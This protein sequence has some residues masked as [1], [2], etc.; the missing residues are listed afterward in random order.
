MV[1]PSPSPSP[2]PHRRPAPSH[3]QRLDAAVDAFVRHGSRRAA[4][5]PL[6]QLT[7][8]VGFAAGGLVVVSLT[9][10]LGS[11]VDIGSWWAEPIVLQKLVVWTMMWQLLG[12]GRG[13]ASHGIGALPPVAGLSYWLTPGTV[14]LAPWPGRVPLTAGT[15][16]TLADVVLYAV[17][18]ALGAG[19]LGF[20]GEAGGRLPAAGTVALL[21]A[22][23]LL[24]L[25]D[26]TPVLAARPELVVPLLVAFLLP[27]GDVLMGVKLVLASLCWVGAVVAAHRHLPAAIATSLA[28]APWLRGERLRTALW[29]RDD[30]DIVPGDAVRWTANLLI[31]VGL[32]LPAVLL[33]A[34][35]GTVTAIAVTVAI[36]L[37]VALASLMA[38]T[39]QLE[40][41]ALLGFATA[42]VFGHHAAVGFDSLSQVA[43][44]AALTLGLLALI[45]AAAAAPRL[46]ATLSPWRHAAGCGPVSLWLLRRDVVARFDVP[47][48]PL[49]PAALDAL[50]YR[51]VARHVLHPNGRALDGLVRR[52]VRVPE[53]YAVRTGEF[54]AGAALGWG[55]DSGPESDRQL[56]AAVQE[57]CG[58]GPGE[59]R[60]VTLAAYSALRTDYRYRIL[61]AATGLVE[62][63]FVDVDDMLDRVPWRDPAAPEIPVE[64]HFS[65]AGFTGYAAPAGYE[66]FGA[67]PVTRPVATVRRPRPT[68]GPAATP[69]PPPA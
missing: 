53:A 64:V 60:V 20:T 6:L 17:V 44:V 5:E 69:A 57:R 23:A 10:G 19:L 11:V 36:G 30:H 41:V 3:Q 45:V 39:S 21:V 26:R 61:D 40:I 47:T 52:A 16:R 27:P 22:L 35:G 62:D 38:R 51:D 34:R 67:P 31:S 66:V 50:H 42:A 63:G 13:V 1:A 58:F 14:R 7:R 28:D 32:V 29:Q 18:L 55:V 49:T 24:G 65:E 54:V 43:P 59:L 68:P 9:D 25:R 56:L 12:L 4:R 2:R 48:R 8:L 46:T 33:F 37:L 15:R